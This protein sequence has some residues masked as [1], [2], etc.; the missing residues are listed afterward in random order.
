MATI[1]AAQLRGSRVIAIF[2]P[3]G[4]YPTRFMWDEFIKSFSSGLRLQDMI[5]L[6]DIYYA[7]GS[8]QKDIS[9]ADLVR[10]IKQKG[11]QAHYAENREKL[12]RFLKK[13]AQEGD[14]IVVMGAR[15]AT[16]SDFAREILINMDEKEDG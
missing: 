13:D 11:G 8:T 6:L 12:L 14:V 1:K 9:S 10:E 5:W 16:L 15:D 3:H 7:G 4:F 2:Q